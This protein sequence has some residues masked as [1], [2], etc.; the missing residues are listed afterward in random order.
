MSEPKILVIDDDRTTLK[1]VE[2]TLNNNGLETI[3]LQNSKEGYNRALKEHPDAII[4][5]QMMPEPDGNQVLERLQSDPETSK[6]PVIM[7]TAKNNIADVSDSLKRGA[8][9]YI[10]KPFDQDNLIARLRNVIQQ[11]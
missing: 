5:D 8:R 11:H 6:I 10:V 3:C 1:I 7:L 2:A 4:L 9:D